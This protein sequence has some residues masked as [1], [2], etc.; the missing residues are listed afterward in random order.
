[1]KDVSRFFLTF[2]CLLIFWFLLAS[3]NFENLIFGT[4]SKIL[5]FF[6]DL[7]FG[8]VYSTI[9]S[10]LFYRIF[11]SR[12]F[13]LR[14]SDFKNFSLHIINWVREEVKM[15]IKVSYAILT[16]RAVN[17]V[18]IEVKYPKKLKNSIITL[19]SIFITAT[20]GTL[21]LN[22]GEDSIFIHSL[23][24]ITKEEVD[25]FCKWLYKLQF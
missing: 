16:G 12:K 8:I 13:A 21:A 9:L 10:I 4:H 2:F 11:L 7:I 1:M 19:I 23:F 20:P 5:S 3:A 15:H 6:E 17:P 18:I 14:L 22:A 24:H 25:R